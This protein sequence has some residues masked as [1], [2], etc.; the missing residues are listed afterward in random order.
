MF[1]SYSTKFM[2]ISAAKEFSL[3]SYNELTLK[4]GIL[5]QRHTKNSHRLF[6]FVNA[7]QSRDSTNFNY[8]KLKIRNMDFHRT[9]QYLQRN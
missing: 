7:R 2:R 3:F 8:L 5:S 9:L 1:I 6:V 4:E